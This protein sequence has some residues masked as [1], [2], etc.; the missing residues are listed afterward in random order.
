M[1][2]ELR[3]AVLVPESDIEDAESLATAIKSELSPMRIK[4]FD[5]AV[6][7]QVVMVAAPSVYPYFRTWMRSRVEQRKSTEVVIDGVRIRGFNAE[8]VERIFDKIEKLTS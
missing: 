1:T 5:G 2:R 4:P 8:E 3:L 7:V 6:L